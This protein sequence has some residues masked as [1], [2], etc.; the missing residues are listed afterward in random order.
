[1]E[2][3]TVGIELG[4]WGEDLAASFLELKGYRICDRN[5]WAGRFEIDLVA[6]DGPLVVFVEVKTRR[7]SKYGSA[8][9]AVTREKL[10][11]VR[12]AALSSGHLRRAD[13]IRF[14]VIAI[15]L[16]PFLGELRLLHLEGV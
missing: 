3:W 7:G 2:G 13:Q 8:V 16:G 4:R 14:D 9:E 1:M 5:L 12:R 10:A 6:R 15:D 11:R